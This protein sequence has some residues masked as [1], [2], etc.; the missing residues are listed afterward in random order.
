LE[1]LLK[2]SDIVSV[3]L[4]LNKETKNMLDAQEFKLMKPT[5]V[6]IQT[7]RGGVVNEQALTDALNSGEIL[8][9]GVDVFEQEP[10]IDSSNPLLFAKNAILTPHIAFATEEALMRRAEI[11]INNVEAWIDGNL[12]NQVRG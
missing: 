6:L 3:H 10:P 8:G 12:Q 9:A 2:E 7:S 4:P 11:T 1:T 5:A